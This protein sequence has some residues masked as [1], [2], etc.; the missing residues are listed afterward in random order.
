MSDINWHNKIIR[1][2]ATMPNSPLAVSA[3]EIQ[4]CF[5]LDK[6]GENPDIDLGSFPEDVTEIGGE[7]TFSGSSNIDTLSSSN[8][9]DVGHLIKITGIREPKMYPQEF[10]PG[11]DIGWA[12]LDQQNKVL[13]YDNQELSGDPISFWR[14]DRM[15]NESLEGGAGSLTGMCY[16]YVD[17]A[18]TAGVPDD[19]TKI[20]ALIDDGN[21]QTLMAIYTIRPGYVGFLLRGELGMSRSITAGQA[22]CAYY[23]RRYEKIFKIKKRVDV[24]NSGNS[25]YQDERSYP[26]VIPALT[27]IRLRV[28]TVSANNTG[29]FGTFDILQVEEKYFKREFLEAIGQPGYEI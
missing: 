18:I 14:V 22:Q 9:A 21:N 19:P 26:D 1:Q 29:V 23:S 10:V 8:L 24:S 25:I 5:P 7:Y 12:V 15:E 11:D 6:F 16:C 28:E 4:G 3:G 17:G 13:I 27:D 20:R 2:L